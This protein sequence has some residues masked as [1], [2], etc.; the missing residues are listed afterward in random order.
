MRG[1]GMIDKD[2]VFRRRSDV[3]YR[4][5]GPEAVV[6]RQ[7]VPEV[8]VLNGVGARVVETIDG[9]LTVGALVSALAGEYAVEREILERDVVAFLGE[10]AEGGVIERVETDHAG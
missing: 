7:S 1:A 2:S 8:L 6:V 3:R 9:T 10:L 4:I 5:V